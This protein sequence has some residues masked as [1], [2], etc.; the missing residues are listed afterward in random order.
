M[1]VPPP[2]LIGTQAELLAL[3]TLL[4]QVAETHNGFRANSPLRKITAEV[5]LMIVRRV[6]LETADMPPSDLRRLA[7]LMQSPKTNALQVD[8]EPA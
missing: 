7:D 1:T 5:H 2:P 8:Q 4:T 6:L 3:A